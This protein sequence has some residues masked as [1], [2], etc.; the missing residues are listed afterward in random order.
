[1]DIE[2]FGW[3]SGS[4]LLMHAC[5]FIVRRTLSKRLEERWRGLRENGAHQG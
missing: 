1:M 3:Q 2:P 4:F 5:G